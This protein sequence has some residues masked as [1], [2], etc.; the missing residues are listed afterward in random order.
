LHRAGPDVADIDLTELNEAF[1]S[2]T[3]AVIRELK[4]YDSKM[5][6]YGGAIALGHPVGATGLIL[7]V[8]L[9]HALRRRGLQR[10][11]PTM[12]VGIARG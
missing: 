7:V 5:N 3:I 11:G 4:L 10:G 8:K 6:V 1:A 2:S 12:W 9:L